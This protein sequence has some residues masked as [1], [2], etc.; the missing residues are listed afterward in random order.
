MI[1]HLNNTLVMSRGGGDPPPFI[2]RP[3]IDFEEEDD[4]E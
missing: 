2:P 4:D 3:W 1:E